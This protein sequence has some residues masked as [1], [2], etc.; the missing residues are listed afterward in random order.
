MDDRPC[1]LWVR[2]MLLQQMEHCDLMKGTDARQTFVDS[3]LTER[4]AWGLSEEQLSLLLWTRWVVRV[5][6]EGRW[7]VIR[8]GDLTRLHLSCYSVISR[9]SSIVLLLSIDWLQKGREHQ[10]A[11][12][13]SSVC[14]RTGF[15]TSWQIFT[16]VNSRSS[17]NMVARTFLNWSN[18]K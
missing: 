11:G 16:N 5:Q 6:K 2:S 18:R 1:A 9:T 14:R 15:W 3:Q 4:T 7:S 13:G 17:W 10:S 8:P 12:P